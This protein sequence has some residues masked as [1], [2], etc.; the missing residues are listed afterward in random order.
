MNVHNLRS[1]PCERSKI[2]DGVEFACAMVEFLERQAVIQP[3][4]RDGHDAG[5][6]RITAKVGRRADSGDTVDALRMAK[7]PTVGDQAAV[8][9][10]HD[11]GPPVQTMM[12]D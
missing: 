6:G 7:S 12:R 11:P 1:S 5:Q 2:I 4:R 3:L 10:S 8:A 9:V